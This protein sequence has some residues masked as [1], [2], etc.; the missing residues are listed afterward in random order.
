MADIDGGI[1]VCSKAYGVGSV[2]GEV[3]LFAA[4]GGVVGRAVGKGLRSAGGVRRAY[5]AKL[6][7]A[8]S[9]GLSAQ[10]AYAF[11][12]YL[13]AELKRKGLGKNFIY[14]FNKW[15]YRKSGDKLGPYFNPRTMK[16]PNK[17]LTDTNLFFDLLKNVPS[18]GVDNLG[19]G[20]GAGAGAAIGASGGS[21]E[22][23]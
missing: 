13:G 2:T 23:R 21:C 15:R 22:C 4:G 9:W 20:L 19:T 7:S 10:E 8:R 16:D 14:A 17:S 6:N 18:S 1:D 12:R 11:R 3:A 5:H